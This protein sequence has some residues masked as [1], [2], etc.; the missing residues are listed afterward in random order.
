VL[1]SPDTF[2][3]KIS[4]GLGITPAIKK[5]TP[6]RNPKGGLP[7]IGSGPGKSGIAIKKNASAFFV[8]MQ[9]KSNAYLKNANL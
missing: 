5:S 7:A 2:W 1:P 8:A 6:K 3:K 9:S 4:S